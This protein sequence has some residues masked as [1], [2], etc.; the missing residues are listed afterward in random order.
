MSA[1]PRIIFVRFLTP[2]SPKRAAWTSHSRLVLKAFDDEAPAESASGLV[3]WQLVSGN[4]RKL[5][6]GIDVIDTFDGARVNAG[7]LVAASDRLE[8]EFVSEAGT[9][10]Y[11]WFASLDGRPVM[12]CARWYVNDRDR[13][14]SVELALRCLAIAELHSGTRLSDPVLSGGKRGT[15]N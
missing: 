3:V 1:G 13:R 14:S 15:L 11:G 10:L 8:I 7:D 6:R 9:G 5:A 4:N 2:G 12:T